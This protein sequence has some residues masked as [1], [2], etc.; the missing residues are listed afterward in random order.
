MV[1]SNY[2]VKPIKPSK[3]RFKPVKP[4][5]AGFCRKIRVFPNT[6]GDGDKI[7]SLHSALHSQDWKGVCDGATPHR[8]RG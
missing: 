8:R 1:F 3:T 4:D 6:G 7:H 2:P 5:P